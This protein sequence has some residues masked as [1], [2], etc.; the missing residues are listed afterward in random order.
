MKIKYKIFPLP[1]G[2]WR[3]SWYL[4]RNQRE[5]LY[6]I[7]RLTDPPPESALQFWKKNRGTD[8]ERKELEEKC[9]EYANLLCGQ[10]VKEKGEQELRTAAPMIEYGCDS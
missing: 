4:D 6:W 5:A 10:L 2:E 9:A 1:N 8:K 3:A 7:S